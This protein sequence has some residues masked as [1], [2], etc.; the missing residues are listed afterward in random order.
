MLRHLHQLIDT[1]QRIVLVTHENPDADAIGSTLALAGYLKQAG[2]DVQVRFTPSIPEFLRFIDEDGLAVCFDPDRDASLGQWAQMWILLDASEVGRLGLLKGIFAAS[3][4]LK[5]CLD[6]HMSTGAKG[7]DHDFTD[8]AASATCE[9][10]FDLI[11]SRMARPIPRSIANALYAGLADDT[12]N[13]RFSNA[14]PK[15]HL[16]AAELIS[17]GVEPAEI[18][19]ALYHQGRPE[20]LK[21]FGKAFSGLRILA[22][23][24]YGALHVT[25]QDLSECGAT[26]DDMD[27]LVNQP[28]TLQG[29]EVASLLYETE[30]GR[31]K[32]SLRSRARVDVNA[33][34]HTFGGGGH[35][36]ASGAKLDG[37]LDDA[38]RLIDAAIIERIS[39]D[40][41]D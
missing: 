20:R 22:G 6:H 18:Y 35:R 39:N 36:L 26:H 29:V 16:M 21:L 14:T 17:D 10:V 38:Q 33:V 5:V 9:R 13:F 34:C 12:G 15:A 31:V 32:A 3:A 11:S 8:S 37:P 41:K 23:G 40:I 25:R 27:G 7:F 28:L 30:D 19:S 1:H 2:K 4:A 24:R